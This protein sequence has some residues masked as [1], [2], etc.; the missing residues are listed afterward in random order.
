MI[1]IAAQRHLTYYLFTITYYFRA[2]GIVPY[3]LG[4]QIPS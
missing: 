1:L 4:L 3:S 2:A